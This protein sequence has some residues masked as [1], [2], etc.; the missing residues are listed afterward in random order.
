M[1]I[2]LYRATSNACVQYAQFSFVTYSRPDLK[3]VHNN[4]YKLYIII[5]ICLYLKESVDDVDC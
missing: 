1:S 3:V 5:I 4:N 2:L